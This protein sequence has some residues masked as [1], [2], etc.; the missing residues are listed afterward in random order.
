LALV[1]F[2]SED[3]NAIHT[4]ITTIYFKIN[5]II[6][7]NYLKRKKST[8]QSRLGFEIYSVLIKREV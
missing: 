6:I 8:K 3:L 1:K 2:I 4:I 5:E 7:G